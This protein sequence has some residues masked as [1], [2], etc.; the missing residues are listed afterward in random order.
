MLAT[1]VAGIHATVKFT[2]KLLKNYSSIYRQYFA[3]HF[4][5]KRELYGKIYHSELN[6]Y[7]YYLTKHTSC[8]S[9]IGIQNENLG[10]FNLHI[11]ENKMKNMDW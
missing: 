6:K 2:V 10:I 7:K 11:Y 9:F 3:V 8:H 5:E 1:Q 4:T